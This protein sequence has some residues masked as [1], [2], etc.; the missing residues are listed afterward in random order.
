MQILMAVSVAVIAGVMVLVL[1]FLIPVM[2]QVRRTSREAEKLI[3]T[4]RIQV[5]PVSRDLGVITRD[6]KHIVQSVQ[7]QVERVEDGVETVH[8]MA[9]RVK[10]FQLDV[11]RK[12]E[13]PLL[14]LLT[15]LE[16]MKKGMELVA[17]VFSR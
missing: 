11:Q 5:S 16:G 8:D 14:N 17:R 13:R 2:L 3:E 6:V 9:L 4:I 7:R 1:I 15:V 10:A 12:M